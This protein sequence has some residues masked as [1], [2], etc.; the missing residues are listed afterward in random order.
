[1]PLLGCHTIGGLFLIPYH[2]TYD[3]A[4]ANQNERKME[5]FVRAD[6]MS[7]ET[8]LVEADRDWTEKDQKSTPVDALMVQSMFAVKT[9]NKL[10]A[11]LKAIESKVSHMQLL[12][13]YTMGG[14]IGATSMASSHHMQLL[15]CCTL[16][17]GIGVPP[18]CQHRCC[19]CCCCSCC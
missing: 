8:S 17:G 10:S 1:M 16:G 6:L 9:L 7:V 12:W 14:A 4:K 2:V 15:G 13:C 18:M 5:D 11:R 3:E 19:C